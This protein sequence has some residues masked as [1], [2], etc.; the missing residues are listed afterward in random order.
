[1]SWLFGTAEHQGELPGP[2]V[3]RGDRNIP[4]AGHGVATCGRLSQVVHAPLI[5]ILGGGQ[6]FF[7]CHFCMV[8]RPSP[9]ANFFDCRP[10][11]PICVPALAIAHLMRR[12]ADARLLH[13]SVGIEHRVPARSASGPAHRLMAA[14]FGW[15]R[16]RRL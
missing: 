3:S 7:P 14:D 11:H 10:R 15:C 12:E 1:V 8:G 16:P 4:L 9:R 13:I 2:E 6:R 5:V